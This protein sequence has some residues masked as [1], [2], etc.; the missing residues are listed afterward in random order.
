MVGLWIIHCL[1]MCLGQCGSEQERGTWSQLPWAL[2]SRQVLIY[3]KFKAL[4][5]IYQGD[6]IP[7]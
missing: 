7:L 1:D 4:T 3:R 2:W 6:K 5:D